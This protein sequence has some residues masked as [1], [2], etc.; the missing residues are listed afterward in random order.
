MVYAV[1]LVCMRAYKGSNTRPNTEHCKGHFASN[2]ILFT[3]RG[4]FTVH[5]MGNCVF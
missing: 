2:A 5:S 1:T 4:A 3:V